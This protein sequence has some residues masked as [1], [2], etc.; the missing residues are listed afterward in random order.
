LREQ[1]SGARPEERA[2]ARAKAEAAQA[3]VTLDDLRI[4]KRDLRAPADGIVLDVHVKSGEVVTPG[5]P[6]FTLADPGQV[7]AFVFVPQGQVTG[8]DVGDRARV[9]ADGLAET[10]VGHVEHI[11][12]RT[13]FTPR[14][15]FSEKER[16]NLVVRVKI[17]I[18]DPKQSLHAGVPV[19]VAIDRN[20][21][22]VART[23]EPVPTT[24]GSA[25][26]RAR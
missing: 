12:R 11:A 16:A 23:I 13:E 24:V 22:V 18:D 14:Y 6:V 17:R 19:R 4:E 20:T 25:A 8:I 15:L 7:Y 3:N 2:S 10:L 1:Q 21:K 26:P 5:A 9:R